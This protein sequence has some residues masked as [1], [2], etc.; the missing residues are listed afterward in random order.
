MTILGPVLFSLRTL[1]HG[2][3]L[4]IAP[5]LIPSL[6]RGIDAVPRRRR[7]GY[8]DG[9]GSGLTS[10]CTFKAVFWCDWMTDKALSSHFFTHAVKLRY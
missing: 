9:G 1:L 7:H 10:E 4:V 5:T 2:V 3:G 8:C 6:T